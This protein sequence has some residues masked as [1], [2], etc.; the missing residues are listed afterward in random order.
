MNIHLPILPILTYSNTLNIHLENDQNTNLFELSKAASSIR[1]Q[2]RETPTS[3]LILGTFESTSD[4]DVI[5]IGDNVIMFVSVIFHDQIML[6]RA[7]VQ[8]E[9]K[10]ESMRRPSKCWINYPMKVKWSFGG[11]G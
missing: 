11:L 6:I 7:S 8:C 2:I 4:D 9:N 10:Q 5:T 3:E 1:F